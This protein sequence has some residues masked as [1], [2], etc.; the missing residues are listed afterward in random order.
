VVEENQSPIIERVWRYLD[1]AK[2]ASLIQNR[3]IYCSRGDKF[4]DIFEGSYPDKNKTL[5][6]GEFNGQDWK[7][8]IVISCWHKNQYESDAMWRLYGLAE[9]GVAIVTSKELLNGVADDH[10]SYVQDVE[11]I[12]F[13][14]DEADIKIPTDVFHYKRKAFEFESEIRMIKAKYPHTGFAGNMPNNSIPIQEH[15][16]PSEGKLI[17]V[18]LNKFIS[19]IIISPYSQPWFY[20]VVKNMTESSELDVIKLSHSEL[21][22]DPIYPRMSID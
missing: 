5:F 19:K 20:D 9:Q 13:R 8:F 15:E 7:K 21:L 18:D 3:K 16:F 6:E 1:L 17:E 10:G 12:D 11:Y 4:N 2:Y 22:G 14:D